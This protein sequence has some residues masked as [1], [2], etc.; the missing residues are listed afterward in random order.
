MAGAMNDIALTLTR[1]ADA[2]AVIDAL[3]RLL[4]PYGG[5]G[6]YGRDRQSS[7]AFLDSEL[8]QLGGLARFM[9]PIFLIVAAFLVNMVLGRLIAIERPQIGL[10]RAV[11][12]T[13]G[14]VAGITSSL[15]R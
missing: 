6:A 4:D 7:H 2:R 15:R 1:D 13:R 3:D 9:P 10:M 14:E 8:Q 12:Y 11:G 5:T